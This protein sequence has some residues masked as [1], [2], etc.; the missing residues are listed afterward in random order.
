[1]DITWLYESYMDITKILYRYLI[2]DGFYI[3]ISCYPSVN[4]QFAIESGHRN[5]LHMPMKD[6]DC[7]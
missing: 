7:Q 6:G 3:D 2:L 1:M 4:E 5:S